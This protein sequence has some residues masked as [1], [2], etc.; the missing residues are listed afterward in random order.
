MTRE[1]KQSLSDAIQAHLRGENVQFRVVGSATGWTDDLNPSFSTCNC[2]GELFEWC[3]A[4]KE[5]TKLYQV[6]NQNGTGQGSFFSEDDAIGHAKS[7]GG[8]VAT[9]TETSRQSFAKKPLRFWGTIATDSG[10]I[11][12]PSKTVAVEYVKKHGGEV[13][14]FQEIVP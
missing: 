13:A 4:P 8:I 1:Q 6:L 7:F 11:W 10:V 9:L 12:R 3:P 2:H 5:P 14:E